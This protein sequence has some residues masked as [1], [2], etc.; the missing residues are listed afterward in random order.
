MNKDDYNFKGNAS[1][2]RG[3]MA[4]EVKDDLRASHFKVG[5]A[6]ESPFKASD[7]AG[8]ARPFSAN[9]A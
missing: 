5:F 2:I 3:H 8:K 4:K 6:Q 1:L 7:T 9:V